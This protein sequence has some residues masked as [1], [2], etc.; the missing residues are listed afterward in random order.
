MDITVASLQNLA[1]EDF[2]HEAE[3]V[4]LEAYGDGAGEEAL[5]RALAAER[6]GDAEKG[7]LWSR[8]YQHVSLHVRLT[9]ASRPISLDFPGTAAVSSSAT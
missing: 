3:H 2:A 1:E 7:R 6:A 5:K 4:L 9:P 8:V